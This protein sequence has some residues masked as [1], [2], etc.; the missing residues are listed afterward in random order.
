MARS[1]KVRHLISGS[2]LNIRGMLEF[3]PEQALEWFPSF[4]TL[5]MYVHVCWISE[6]QSF[7]NKGI[8]I[9]VSSSESLSYFS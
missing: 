3:L 6:L 8:A 1:R 2:S 4:A 7:S 9:I 5:T